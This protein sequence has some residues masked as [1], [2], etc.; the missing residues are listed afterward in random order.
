MWRLLGNISPLF[1]SPWF[2]KASESACIPIPSET[3]FLF[4]GFNVSEGDMTLFGIVAA[5]VL[6]LVVS[7]GLSTDELAEAGFDSRLY[8]M[9]PDGSFF[10]LTGFDLDMLEV[11]REA[12]RILHFDHS[13]R[14]WMR[15]LGLK[16]QKSSTRAA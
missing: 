13:D 7:L 15:L 6:M 8:V 10:T 4:A 3:T 16:D 14:P 11:W 9:P 5:G 2:A 12:T 1:T